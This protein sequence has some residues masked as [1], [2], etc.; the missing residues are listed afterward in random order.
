M[1]VRGHLARLGLAGALALAGTP[2]GIAAPGSGPWLEA[3][4]ALGG[5]ALDEDLADYRWDTSPATQWGARVLAGRGPFALGLGAWRSGTTQDTG[6]PGEVPPLAVSVSAVALTGLVR[7]ATPLGWELRLGGQAGRLHAGWEPASLKV[8]TGAGEPVD[9]V[10]EDI[11][12]WL[13]GVTAEVQRELGR[14]LVAVAQADWSSFS[15]ET[16][17]R[18]GDAIVEQRERFGAWSARVQ[19]GWRWSR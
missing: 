8:D 11:D 7:V 13:V 1:T 14:G 16:A 17:H 18:R 3:G 2:A 4:A 12:E 5:L 10:F 19:V 9:V 15:L 6:L